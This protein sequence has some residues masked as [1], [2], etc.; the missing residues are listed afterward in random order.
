[1]VDIWSMSRLR[2]AAHVRCNSVNSTIGHDIRKLLAFD[3]ALS[4]QPLAPLFFVSH[5]VLELSFA[6]PQQKEAA[7]RVGGRPLE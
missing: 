7:S 3:I 2:S 4:P 6:L 5:T 1:M